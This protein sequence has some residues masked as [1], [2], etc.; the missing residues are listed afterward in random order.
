VRLL[1]FEPT[2]LIDFPTKNFAYRACDEAW[3]L[4]QAIDYQNGNPQQYRVVVLDSGE[5]QLRF[6]SP[7]P[8]WAHRRLTSLG[9]QV[10]APDC[11]LAYSFPSAAIAADEAHFVELRMW[12]TRL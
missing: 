9:E 12:L 4:Q 6:L 3:H 11:L 5:V 2:S 1:G 8:Q 7:I 10:D